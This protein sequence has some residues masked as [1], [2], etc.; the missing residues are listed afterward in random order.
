MCDV[1]WRPTIDAKFEVSDDG[2][3]RSAKNKRLR[4]QWIN[5]L[6]TL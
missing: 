2:Q 1:E 4:K 6:A 3:I 5:S